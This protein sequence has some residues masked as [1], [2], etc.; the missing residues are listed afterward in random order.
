MKS[1]TEIIIENI[2]AEQSAVLIA[3]LSE[4]G[5]EGF[6]EADNSLKAFINK[7][8]FDEAFLQE[9]SKE[10]QFNYSTKNIEEQNWN[11]LWESNFEPVVV[12]DFVTVR[13]HFHASMQGTQHEILITPK[14]SFGTGHHATTY[15]MMQQMRALDF[16]G[17]SVFDF[18]TGTG[19]LAIL[20]EKLG[21]QNIF[22]VDNDDWSVENAIENVNNN[23]GKNIVVE[24]A[25]DAS[26]KNE[27]Y[28]IVLAN[29][30]KNVILVNAQTLNDVL[31]NNGYLLL[32]GLLKEDE[33][34]IISIFSAFGLQHLNTQQRAQWISLLW[35]KS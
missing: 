18:G 3:L 32:S 33:M 5:F 16:A 7:E 25:F 24:K 11:A 28:D 30:N 17:K 26:A 13:A 6:E 20:A 19:V 27:Q 1:Y 31:S 14:M 15:M 29:I 4:D 8:N 23:A 22:A 10:Y 2:S 34:D 35:R 9:L 21:A 12:D